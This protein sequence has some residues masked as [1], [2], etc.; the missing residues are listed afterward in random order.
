MLVPYGLAQV[1]AALPALAV[2]VGALIAGEKIKSPGAAKA[3]R[4]VGLLA[5]G[6]LVF[7]PYSYSSVVWVV[8]EGPGGALAARRYLL[9]GQT[10]SATTLDGRPIPLTAGEGPTLV[11]NATQGSLVVEAAHYGST[12]GSSEKPEPLAPGTS[13]V[14]GYS[15][16]D[17]GDPPP[18]AQVKESSPVSVRH[19]IRRV[20]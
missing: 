16:N 6:V 10:G 11:A 15:I 5:A 8:D 20:R 4:I 2:A 14:Y 1:L 19:Y 13:R 17:V 7:V 9:W 12:F 18:T 3:L